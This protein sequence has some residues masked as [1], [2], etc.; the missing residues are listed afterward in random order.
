[1]GEL[2]YY[3]YFRGQPTCT[4]THI[5][6]HIPE[7]WLQPGSSKLVERYAWR[8]RNLQS[9]CHTDATKHL[10]TVVFLVGRKGCLS[11]SFCRK[12]YPRVGCVSL[13]NGSTRSSESHHRKSFVTQL[14][15]SDN[16]LPPFFYVYSQKKCST[17]HRPPLTPLKRRGYTKEIRLPPPEQ[18]VSCEAGWACWL[19]LPQKVHLANGRPANQTAL[20]RPLMSTRGH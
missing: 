3:T 8:R 9:P 6:T 7:T 12:L 15:A 18:A 13:E 16:I 14:P 5:N 1:M 11:S 20:H 10:N 4:Y 19:A 2:H 17:F